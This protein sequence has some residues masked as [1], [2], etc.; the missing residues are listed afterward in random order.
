MSTLVVFEAFQIGV[1]QLDDWIASVP[2]FQIPASFRVSSY[3]PE[4]ECQSRIFLLRNPSCNI[5]RL[6]RLKR[7]QDEANKN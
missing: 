4:S 3:R 7:Y 5:Q 2:V 6:S 1:H